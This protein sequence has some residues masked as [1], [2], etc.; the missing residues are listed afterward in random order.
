MLVVSAP[1]VNPRRLH[2]SNSRGQI[3]IIFGP[4]FSGKTTELIRRLKRYEVANHSCLMIKY[5]NDTRYSAE[6]VSTHDHQT[7]PAVQTTEL[8]CLKDESK[9]YSV[10]GIDEGQFFSDIVEFAEEM[11]NIGKVVIVAALDGTYQRQGFGNILFLVPLA[12]SVIKLTAVC[13]NCFEEA[14]YTKRK[15][16]EKQVEIIGGP[17]K[18]KSVC[19][20][21]YFKVSPVKDSTE[22]PYS[23]DKE[24]SVVVR[25]LNVN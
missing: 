19:R 20:A 9:K 22:L 17:E 5:A 13:M 6:Q 12:E 23:M 25:Q 14:S 10:I 3:Q 16:S 11:A 2:A 4:M 1:E 7:L 15:G 24:R 18:Y 8:G 21:C